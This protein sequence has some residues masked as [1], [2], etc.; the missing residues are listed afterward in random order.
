VFLTPEE[1]AELTSRRRRPAQ[2][3]QL[4]AMGI[5][6]KVRAD[7]SIAVLRAHVERVFGA[8]APAEQRKAKPFTIRP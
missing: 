3:V 6:Y 7:G 5:E 1:L 8:A 4:N 2:Q